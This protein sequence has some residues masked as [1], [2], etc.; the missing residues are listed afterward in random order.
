MIRLSSREL[1]YLKIVVNIDDRL[2]LFLFVETRGGKPLLQF[3]LLGGS[4]LSQRFDD[5]ERSLVG[6]DV[7]SH[8]LTEF[9][10]VT[11][12]VQQVVPE[13]KPNADACSEFPK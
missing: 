11:I 10:G 5:Q 8:L 12:R 13:L 7:T 6:Y 2:D 1:G 3:F 9:F 4:G